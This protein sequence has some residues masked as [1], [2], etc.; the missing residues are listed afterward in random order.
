LPWKDLLKCGIDSGNGMR[1]RVE[2]I[3]FFCGNGRQIAD[4][5]NATAPAWEGGRYKSERNL[6]GLGDLKVAATQDK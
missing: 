6:R 2:R 3:S 4:P 1:E 5:M